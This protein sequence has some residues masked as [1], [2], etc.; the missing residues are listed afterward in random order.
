LLGDYPN[1][2]KNRK[3]DIV[4]NAVNGKSSPIFIVQSQGTV[5][6][7]DAE[8]PVGFSDALDE[9]LSGA[10]TVDGLAYSSSFAASGNWK[11]NNPENYLEQARVEIVAM[12]K[13]VDAMLEA[14][15]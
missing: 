3:G 5:I 12:R 8:D 13:D 6:A 11:V 15:R 7:R 10:K 4:R 14:L 2:V 9:F 1:I